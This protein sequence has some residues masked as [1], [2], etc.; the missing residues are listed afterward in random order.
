MIPSI[1]FDKCIA[2]L[3]IFIPIV[4]LSCEEQENDIVTNFRFLS[5]KFQSGITAFDMN[6]KVVE[7][8][9]IFDQI[10][11]LF[12]KDR[13]YE[14][15]DEIELLSDHD[16]LFSYSSD[17]FG[18]LKLNAGYTRV[19]NE[20]HFAIEPINETSD[21]LKIVFTENENLLTSLAYGTKLK[22]KGVSMEEIVVSSTGYKT[23]G[24]EKIF[25]V[26]SESDTLY[27]QEFEV[28]Y[29]KD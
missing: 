12:D 18:T 16:A 7:S 13:G 28:T 4:F 27:V 5:F 29:T 26:M 2:I 17:R 15:A 3:F 11:F 6:G 9:Q 22:T 21:T 8:T 10:D 23:P 19:F 25:A 1:T 14:P 20:I 24:L